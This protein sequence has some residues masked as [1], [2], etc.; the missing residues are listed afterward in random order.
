MEMRKGFLWPILG[1]VLLLAFSFRSVG[2]SLVPESGVPVSSL[3]VKSILISADTK[4]ELNKLETFDGRLI[5]VEEVANRPLEKDL[6]TIVGKIKSEGSVELSNGE[7]ISSE[8]INLLHATL[9]SLKEA[10]GEIKKRFGVPVIMK[11]PHG[12]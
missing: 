10:N 3:A 11:F 7:V 6:D 4:M 12:D 8:Q 5:S 2:A 1:I 9:G